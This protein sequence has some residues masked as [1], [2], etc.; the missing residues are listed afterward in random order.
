MA[1]RLQTNFIVEPPVDGHNHA[2][3]QGRPMSGFLS[4]RARRKRAA[5]GFTLIELL[6]VIAIIAILAAMLLPALAKAKLKAKSANCVSNQKQLALAWTMYADDNQGNIIN[7]DA[8][9]N[10]TTSE[11]IPWRYSVP[12]PLPNMIGLSPADAD[13]AKLQEG[14]KQGGL[15]QYAPNVSVLHCPADARYNVSAVGNTTTPPGSFAY[16]SYSGAGGM[17]GFTYESAPLKKQANIVHASERYL[18]VEENDPRGE[19]LGP[20]GM[21]AP[22]PPAFTDASFVDSVAAWHGNSS[23]FSWADGHADNH[24]WLS[25]KTV[26]Y[27]LSSDPTKYSNGALLPTF[28]EASADLFFLANGYADQQNP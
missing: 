6:V 23:S 2:P 4:G 8:P 19:N 17:N 25:S 9:V 12:N 28:A 5:G 3:L 21:H 15:Y 16:G 24:R 27:A 26:A 13:V 10:P 11:T 20:W 14:Y 1:K 22:T 7:F 18:W